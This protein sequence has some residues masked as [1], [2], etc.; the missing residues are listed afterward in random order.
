MFGAPSS[1]TASY[2]VK[3][4]QARCLVALE[5]DT[6]RNR[7]VVGS[8]DLRGDNE[9]HVL[10]FNEDTN[11]VACQKAFAHPHEIWSCASCPAPEHTELLCTTYSTGSEL[12]TGLWR[13]TGIADAGS[14]SVTGG[15]TSGALAPAPLQEL[16]HLR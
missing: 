11:E 10:E 8:L 2:Q 15:A 6:D 4:Q 3:Q 13:M 5:G 9:L 14:E 7:F 1:A 12:K 16:A